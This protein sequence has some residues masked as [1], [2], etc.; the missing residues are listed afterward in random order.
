ME[1]AF[2]KRFSRRKAKQ[3]QSTPR[4]TKEGPQGAPR[5]LVKRPAPTGH[6]SSQVRVRSKENQVPPNSPV[7]KEGP[8]RTPRP[9][10]KRPALTGHLNKP[11]GAQATTTTAGMSPAL[12]ASRPNT[13]DFPH[14]ARTEGRQGQLKR[15]RSTLSPEESRGVKKRRIS[16]TAARVYD[17]GA[18]SRRDGRC[19]GSRASSSAARVHDPGAAAGCQPVGGSAARSAAAQIPQAPQR[20]R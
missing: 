13:Q 17:P 11:V 14:Q 10:V 3:A 20:K 12:G 6:P 9:L 8:Q 4:V 16:S 1:C 2:S 5:P 7:P 19:V 18:A 15:P